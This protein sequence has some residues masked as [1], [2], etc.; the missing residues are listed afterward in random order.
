MRLIWRKVRV[1]V[2]LLRIRKSKLPD[3]LGPF[4]LKNFEYTFPF[5]NLSQNT[6][7]TY[8]PLFQSFKFL[9][10]WVLDNFGLVICF[11]PKW[12][13]TVAYRLEMPLLLKSVKISKLN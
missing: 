9:L 12:Y 1:V 5:K 10:R 11:L 2:M 3:F 6:E 4:C 8:P 13:L 7:G